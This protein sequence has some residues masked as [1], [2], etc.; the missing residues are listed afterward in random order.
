MDN[1][2]RFIEAARRRLQRFRV[3]TYVLY[4]LMAGFAALLPLLVLGRFV[5]IAWLPVASV[6]IPVGAGFVGLLWDGCIGF[7]SKRP[8]L[9]WIM[10]LTERSEVT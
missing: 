2:M 10:F 1:I 6:A 7:R 3:I 5:P 8:L 9:R 4:G